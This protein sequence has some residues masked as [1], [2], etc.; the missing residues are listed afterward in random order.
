[1]LHFALSRARQTAVVVFIVTSLAFALIHSVPGDPFALSPED[2]PELAVSRARV[3]EAYGLD[4]PLATQ[5]VRMLANFARGRLGDSFTETRPVSRV[6]REAMPRTIL[7]MAP[8][9]LVGVLLGVA[10]GTWQ[11]SRQGKLDDRLLGGAALATLSLP[12]FLIALIASTIFALRLKWLPAAGMA[13]A[14]AGGSSLALAGDVARHLILPAG[15]LA[16]V[17]AALVSR[18]Q[19]AAAVAA[20]QEDFVRTARAKGATARRV[21]LA[22]VLRRTAGSLCTVVGFLLPSLVGGAALVENVF[23]WPGAGSALLRAVVTRDYPL[24]IGLVF[25]GSFAVCIASALAEAGAA[26]ANPATR[27]RA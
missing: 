26:I 5:Y 4:Q 21:M 19:R 7:L 18:F 20:F 2:P 12:E 24:V 27:A 3:R 14:D 15:T 9:V 8:A 13:T 11:A 17:V 1:M 16:L 6:I 23:G 25:V 10:A 22:H